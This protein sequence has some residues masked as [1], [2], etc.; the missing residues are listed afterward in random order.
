MMRRPLLHTIAAVAVA[1][2]AGGFVASDAVRA[3][4][5][6]T[7][8]GQIDTDEPDPNQPMWFCVSVDG[9]TVGLQEYYYCQGNPLP[10]RLPIPS[11]PTPPALPAPPTAP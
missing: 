3:E 10:K 8:V 6:N 7:N 5:I 2:I 11:T 4:S 1:T 9:R